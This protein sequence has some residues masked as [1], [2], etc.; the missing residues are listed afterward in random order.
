VPVPRDDLLAD[1]DETQRAAVVEP[2]LPLAILAPAGSGKTRVLTR[3]IAWHCATERIDAGH[4]LAVTFTRKAA[5]ELRHRL[6]RLG[7]RG[8]V[9]AGTFHSVA[10]AQLRARHHERGTALPTLLDRKGRILAPLVGGGARGRGGAE[11]AVA[12][13]EV[14]AEI[15]WAKARL[16]NPARY[17]A[18]VAAA[19]RDTPR[20][21]AE[22]ARVYDRYEKEKRKRSLYDFDDLLWETIRALEGDAEFAAVQ[23]WRFRHLFVDEFQDAT[24]AQIRLLRGWLGE[25]TDLCVVGDPDQA[26]YGFAGA[27]TACL[28]DFAER[29]PGGST[30][31]LGTNYRSTPQ[32]VDTAR[33]VLPVRARAHVRAAGTDGPAPTITAYPTDGDE[34]R[35]VATRLRDA[36]D[37]QR[38]WSA[39]AVL[40]RVNAQSAPFEEALRHAGIPFRVRGGAAFLDRPE[41]KAVLDG[42]RKSAKAAPARGFTEHLTDLVTEAGEVSEE[43]REHVDAVASLGREYLAVE[44]GVGS[45]PGFEQYLR[46]ALRGGDDGGLRDDAVELL[47]FHRAKGLEWDTVFVTGLERGL[48]PISHAVGDPEATDE[49]R[50]L[51]YV[52]LSRA[53]RALHLTWAQERARGLRRAKRAR[54]PFLTEIERVRRGEAAVAPRRPDT[55]RRGAAGARAALAQIDAGDLDAADRLLYDELVAWRRD[56]ARASNVP[57]YVIF[58]NKVLLGVATTRPTSGPD[59]LAL[60]GIGSVKLERYGA[61]LLEVVGRHRGGSRATDA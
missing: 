23:R 40:Y 60:P 19:R 1:L 3:R 22:V 21:A 9:T 50:R 18:A 32:I 16:V 28:T 36:H 43:R 13:N 58:D 38:G 26:I 42:L 7:V 14:A 34:A 29:F 44:G 15:E 6:S 11:L 53:E 5:G 33:T 57:A 59:L 51:L 8:A 61:A 52:A 56:L 37:P 35:A 2:A 55:N 4:V 54:S 48:V 25:R 24:R 12:I 47:T 27:E 20:S 39:T 46:A 10:L 49:E 41:V 31:R 30:V 17:E 45:V